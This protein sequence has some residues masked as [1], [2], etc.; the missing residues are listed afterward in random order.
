MRNR[1][2]IKDPIDPSGA[3]LLPVLVG[4]TA[5]AGLRILD[6]SQGVVAL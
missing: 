3:T 5:T 4:I 2:L 1:V 6:L